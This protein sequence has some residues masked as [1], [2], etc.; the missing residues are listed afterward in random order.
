MKKEEWEGECLGWFGTDVG[1]RE[2]SVVVSAL[3]FFG[4]AVGCL[5]MNAQRSSLVCH[6]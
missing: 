4:P 6:T 1:L 2:R 5:P 3:S